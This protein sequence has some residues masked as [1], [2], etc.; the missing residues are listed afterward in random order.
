MGKSEIIHFQGD[1]QAQAEYPRRSTS[2]PRK[3]CKNEIVHS[4]ANCETELPPRETST[5]KKLYLK[6]TQKNRLKSPA[7]KTMF[8]S[9]NPSVTQQTSG[10]KEH[11]DPVE[12]CRDQIE[13]LCIS[14]NEMKNI[15]NLYRDISKLSDEFHTG[16][17]TKEFVDILVFLQ[18]V[19]L[20]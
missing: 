9:K 15:K 18:L 2:T 8:K 19:H 14:E 11:L 20:V 17:R 13:T 1:N 7:L 3:I 5:P 10:Q 6:T 12:I 4:T 16:I